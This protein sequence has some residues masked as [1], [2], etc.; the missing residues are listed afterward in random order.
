MNIDLL[1]TS[2]RNLSI[3]CQLFAS[4]MSALLEPHGLTPAQF[5]ILNHIARPDLRESGTRVSDIAAAVEVGQPAV[6]KTIAKF[7]EMA[8]VRLA[9]SPT[10][11]RAKI[12]HL[13][14]AGGSFLIGVQ[15]ALGPG[16]AGLFADIPEQELIAFNQT[17]GKLLRWLDANRL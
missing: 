11:Q 1:K 3:L 10:D 2:T 12:I 16:L 17:A 9:P 5:G 15:K 14:D 13:T 8:L 4:R 7:E 6:T